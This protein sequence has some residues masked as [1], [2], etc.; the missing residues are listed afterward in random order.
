MGFYKVINHCLK[1]KGGQRKYLQTI[2]NTK[3]EFLY[4]IKNSKITIKNGEN[5]L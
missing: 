1:G 4:K 3:L 5:G 2:K